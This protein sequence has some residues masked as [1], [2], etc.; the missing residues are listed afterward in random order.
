MFWIFYADGCES[1]A[2][3]PDHRAHPRLKASWFRPSFCLHQFH[4]TQHLIRISLGFQPRT[5][6][7]FKMN[8]WES[9]FMQSPV[10]NGYY[11]ENALPQQ[12]WEWPKK[13]WFQSRLDYVREHHSSLN[14]KSSRR[15]RNIDELRTM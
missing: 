12:R 1:P 10:N 15:M 5:R 11:E 9:I 7:K 3:I 6:S 13:T 14:L 8:A 2:P 4:I